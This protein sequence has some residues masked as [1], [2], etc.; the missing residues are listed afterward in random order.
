MLIKFI[1]VIT[2]QYIF[3]SS[4]YVT[5]LKLINFLSPVLLT[6]LLLP[7]SRSDFEKEERE[8]RTKIKEYT[9]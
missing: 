9:L 1:V 6:F 8:E 3:I 2:S 7:L 4:H 5:H